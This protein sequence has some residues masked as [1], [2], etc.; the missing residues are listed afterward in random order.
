MQHGAMTLGGITLVPSPS[1]NLTASLFVK[2]LAKGATERHLHAVFSQFGVVMECQIARHRSGRSAGFAIISYNKREEAALALQAADGVVFLGR[3]LNIRWYSSDTHHG[4][5]LGLDFQDNLNSLMLQQQLLQQLMLSG[6]MPQSQLT[7]DQLQHS[8][9]PGGPSWAGDGSVQGLPSAMTPMLP[10]G[11]V[12]QES[13]PLPLSAPSHSFAGMAGQQQ[14]GAMGGMAQWQA[15]GLT[16][17]GLNLASLPYMEMGSNQFQQD[18]L[19]GPPR[20]KQGSQNNWPQTEEQLATMQAQLQ[21]QQAQLQQQQHQ[22]VLHQAQ[23]QK[24][25]QPNGT[26][27]PTSVGDDNHSLGSSSGVLPDSSGISEPSL[28]AVSSH[29]QTLCKAISNADAA[30]APASSTSLPGTADSTGR[31]T[32]TTSRD[33][34]KPDMTAAAAL[35]GISPQAG[36]PMP[37]QPA[38]QAAQQPGG[39]AQAEAG[40]PAAPASLAPQAGLVMDSGSQQGAAGLGQGEMRGPSL[41]ALH[42]LNSQQL[43]GFMLM[44]DSTS[45]TPGLCLP[46][47]QPH[48]FLTHQFHPDAD[49]HIAGKLGARPHMLQHQH[50]HQQLS[51]PAMV[52]PSIAGMAGRTMLRPGP[53]LAPR[54]QL[55]EQHMLPP[56]SMVGRSPMLSGARGTPLPHNSRVPR[57]P[58]QGL[59]SMPMF[60]SAG[61]RPM[62]A[63]MNSIGGQ[64][65]TATM[66][67]MLPMLQQ[68]NAGAGPQG[69]PPQLSAMAAKS[70]PDL[71]L[72]GY[73]QPG[74]SAGGMAGMAGVAGVTPPGPAVG[75]AA[76]GPQQGNLS[77]HQLQAMLSAHHL[78][79]AQQQYNDALAQL[80]AAQSQVLAASAA[81]HLRPVSPSV[82]LL[83]PGLTEGAPPPAWLAA[84]WCE[85]GCSCTGA[86]LLLHPSCQE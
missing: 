9:A 76:A 11:P 32:G 69:L 62:A 45:S 48:M 61:S 4:N 51:S 10:G 49:A 56:P 65:G 67:H 64:M 73:R 63:R 31:G 26:S 40:H 6:Q 38:S 14:L 82:K 44:A 33:S 36:V 24:H 75:E 23:Q 70:V 85:T 55:H 71:A 81:L 39:E 80:S 84:S 5:V 77:S 8:S 17:E 47:Q 66:N 25:A 60:N 46:Q 52:G 74:N 42:H 35:A 78:T 86:C 12:Y 54:M 2:G 58:G 1:S 72:L 83:P 13:T 21:L 16:L 43:S 3:R 28:Q 30:T 59:P 37:R 79:T 68:P 7:P 41:H 27:T 57:V 53:Q 22:Q 19:S 34:S 20:N 15:A 50:Q 18:N 29:L